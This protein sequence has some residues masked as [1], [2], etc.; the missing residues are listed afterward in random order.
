MKTWLNSLAAGVVASA[1]SWS[2]VLA[3]SDDVNSL[4]GDLLMARAFTGEA[5]SCPIAGGEQSRESSALLG[6]VV[7]TVLGGGLRWLS[8]TLARNQSEEAR[9]ILI[10]AHTHFPYYAPVEGQGR[11]VPDLPACV[12]FL[13]ND[14]AA[15]H[16]PEGLRDFVGAI[17][18]R[19]LVNRGN[20]AARIDEAVRVLNSMGVYAEPSFYFEAVPE[21]LIDGV[22][23]NPRALHYAAPISRRGRSREDRLITL[24][25]TLSAISANGQI[26]SDH[27]HYAPAFIFQLRP[28]SSLGESDFEGVVSDIFPHAPIPNNVALLANEL[29]YC[30][31]RGFDPFARPGPGRPTGW[32]MLDTRPSPTLSGMR[33]DELQQACGNYAR[34]WDREMTGPDA[35]GQT[36]T[37]T[38]QLEE[39]RNANNMALA[40][41]SILAD[42]QIRDGLVSEA[43]SALGTNSDQ[44][45]LQ[46]VERDSTYQLA[47]IEL[48]SARA[49]Y[50]QAVESGDQFQITNARREVVRALASARRA[51]IQAGV[52]PTGLEVLDPGSA[53]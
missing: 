7:S 8:N 23:F 26:R 12:I 32:G 31:A 6:Q 42:Q 4:R 1:M 5:D 27:Q 48:S 46:R 33:P 45:A 28:G 53:P 39:V 41:S 38:F 24:D 47:L 51:A 13:A 52:D 14:Q 50:S 36:V 34:F 44:L 18:R 19:D 49:A 40:L 11:L 3:Q 2:G 35:V 17:I 43:Q 37:I 20:E 30:R 22:I 16:D 9:T 15:R 10:N 21:V 29:A 25:I